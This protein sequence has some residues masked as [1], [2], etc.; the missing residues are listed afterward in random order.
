VKGRR[1][2]PSS[3]ECA[4]AIVDSEMP[5]FNIKNVDFDIETNVDELS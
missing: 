1:W 5:S 2:V 3:H 4:P